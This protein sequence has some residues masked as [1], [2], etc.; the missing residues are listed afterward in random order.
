MEIEE[1]L[2]R[3]LKIETSALEAGVTFDIAAFKTLRQILWAENSIG[4]IKIH[5]AGNALLDV[6]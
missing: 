3:V 6:S 1:R 4:R 2:C 5:D